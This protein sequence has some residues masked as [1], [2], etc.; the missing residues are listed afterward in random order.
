M[1]LNMLTQKMKASLIAGAT[2]GVVCITGASIRSVKKNNQC[3]F[4]LLRDSCIKNC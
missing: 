1:M 3:Q 4:M 2:L